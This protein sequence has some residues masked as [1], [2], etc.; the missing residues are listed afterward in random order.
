VDPSR[1]FYTGASA[2]SPLAA[3]LCSHL[4]PGTTLPLTPAAKLSEG[5]LST[6]IRT[7]S[8]R[9]RELGFVHNH[10]TAAHTAV[11]CRKLRSLFS[12]PSRCALARWPQRALILPP[13]RGMAS[14]A[15]SFACLTSRSTSNTCWL[16]P[17]SW[18]RASL[19]LSSSAHRRRGTL[20]R[21][22]REAA[23]GILSIGVEGA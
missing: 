23:Y 3:A 10:T 11:A 15:A 6:S 19:A 18:L 20:P 9:L 12:A 13:C 16:L 1:R 4:G 22:A 7:R 21:R 14:V 2:S 17:A 5:L 8:R